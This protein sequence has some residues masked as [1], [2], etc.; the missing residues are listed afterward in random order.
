MTHQ[1]LEITSG[2][3]QGRVLKIGSKPVTIGRA[4]GNVLKLNDDTAS[5]Q[6]AKVF[7]RGGRVL[8]L[9]LRSSHG[10]WVNG[11][12]VTQQELQDLDELKIGSTTLSYRVESG[13]PASPN[14]GQESDAAE[15]DSGFTLEMPA[16]FDSPAAPAETDAAPGLQEG[17]DPFA[18]DDDVPPLAGSP[19]ARA[20][21]ATTSGTS[22]GRGSLY[23]T[24]KTATTNTSKFGVLGHDLDQR[25]PLF[26]WL[27]MALVIAIAIGLGWLAMKAAGLG[28]GSEATDDEFTDSPPQQGPN[29]PIRPGR[30]P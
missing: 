27:A 13:A 19:T 11:E 14:A 22:G 21:Q 8:V 30:S 2:P 28:G 5:R 4:P 29:R 17:E 18:E 1:Q 7:V 6:H 3:D 20:G 16:E 10:T 12:R 25:G 26:R 9:D 15:E 23:R 24:A